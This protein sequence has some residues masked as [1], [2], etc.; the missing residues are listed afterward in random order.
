[1]II[2]YVFY[3]VIL[4]RRYRKKITETLRLNGLERNSR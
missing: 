3:F 2:S 1:M 4:G